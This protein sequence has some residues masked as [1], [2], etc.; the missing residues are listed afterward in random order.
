MGKEPDF[1]VFPVPFSHSRL[2]LDSRRESLEG[3]EGRG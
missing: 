3:G 2:E 1:R